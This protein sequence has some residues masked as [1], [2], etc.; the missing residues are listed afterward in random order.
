M[1]KLFSLIVLVVFL[2]SSTDAQNIRK[3]M[4]KKANTEVPEQVVSDVPETKEKKYNLHVNLSKWMINSVS[5]DYWSSYIYSDYAQGDENVQD[6]YQD[7][8]RKT[9]SFSNTLCLGIGVSTKKEISRKFNL[10]YGIGIDLAGFRFHINESFIGNHLVEK[11]RILTESDYTPGSYEV[12]ESHPKMP[13]DERDY[14]YIS[15]PED[16]ALLL[17]NLPLEINYKLLNKLDLIGGVVARIP[18][19]ESRTF[20]SYDFNT[21]TDILVRDFE[22]LVSRYLLFGSLGLRYQTVEGITIGLKY[23]HL[24][25]SLFIQDSNLFEEYDFDGKNITVQQ[26]DLSLGY[27]F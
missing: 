8:I 10:E 18:L 14:Y 20:E 15:G 9:G 26:L 3:R 19:I 22:P 1:K 21:Q 12:L 27:S 13:Y 24:F 5:Y 4:S 11:R 23:Q 6:Y 16:H 7:Q 2:V 25:N 17:L